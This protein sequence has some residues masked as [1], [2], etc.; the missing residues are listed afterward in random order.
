MVDGRTGFTRNGSSP[1]TRALDA[2]DPGNVCTL[3]GLEASYNSQNCLPKALLHRI[4]HN[5]ILRVGKR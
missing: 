5:L 1:F 3:P 2:T 4:Q